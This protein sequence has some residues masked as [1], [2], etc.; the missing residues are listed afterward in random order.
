M[1]RK[2][3]MNP[4]PRRQNTER[5][6]LQGHAVMQ[7]VFSQDLRSHPLTRTN[8]KVQPIPLPPTPNTTLSSR[9]RISILKRFLNVTS[10]EF[11]PHT[12]ALPPL[13]NMVV[14]V[15]RRADEHLVIEDHL[16]AFKSIPEL[17]DMDM[18]MRARDAGNILGVAV[19][20]P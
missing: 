20:D 6:K 3:K 12:A 13:E 10:L 17:E 16:R 4:F 19:R 5:R 11:N 15:L 1:N 2:G 14:P 9:A 7:N 8:S 18:A